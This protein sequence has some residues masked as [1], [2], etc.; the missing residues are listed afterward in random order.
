MKVQQKDANKRY[1]FKELE[2]SKIAEIFSRV[3]SK[4]GEVYLWRKG[5]N[6]DKME[7]FL[8]V[9]VHGQT[10]RLQIKGLLAQIGISAHVDQEVFFKICLDKK[11][12]FS[13]ARL[14]IDDQSA[15]YCLDMTGYRL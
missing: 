6:K 7:H 8:V 1:Y 4:K 14:Y 12:Y 10:L 13:S 5:E 11:Q 9:G 15:D 2:S 3:V